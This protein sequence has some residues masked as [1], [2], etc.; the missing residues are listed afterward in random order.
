M[1]SMEMGPGINLLKNRVEAHSASIEREKALKSLQE[2][3]LAM[4][5][6]EE[7]KEELFKVKE[8]NQTRDTALYH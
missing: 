4:N 6:T 3:F 1:P 7:E 2:A 5:L 8:D